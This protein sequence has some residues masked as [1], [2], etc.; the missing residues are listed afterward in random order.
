MQNFI[1]SRGPQGA[2]MIFFR[3]EFGFASFRK[4]WPSS[5][6]GNTQLAGERQVQSGGA[7][8]SGLRLSCQSRCGPTLS[9]R[10]RSYSFFFFWRP[11]QVWRDDKFFFLRWTAVFVSFSTIS[12]SA[13][14][15]FSVSVSVT[16]ILYSP[17]D[18]R[19]PKRWRYRI[20]LYEKG[21]LREYSG[22]LRRLH[23]C[24][25]AGLS[26]SQPVDSSRSFK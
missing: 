16:C 2:K 9:T 12:E 11:E 6:P 23:S 14:V 7:G 4:L 1:V 25:G 20:L 17:L 26:H 18:S 22:F 10:A 3:N 19:R 13:F 21:L 15:S 8:G 5:E 24:S